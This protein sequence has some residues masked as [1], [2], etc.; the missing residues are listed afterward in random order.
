MNESVKGSDQY[1]LLVGL[2]RQMQ[3]RSHFLSPNLDLIITQLTN[4]NMYESIACQKIKLWT[5][6]DPSNNT[7][8]LYKN[9]IKIDFGWIDLLFSLLGI[10][11]PQ[12]ASSLTQ[13]KRHDKFFCP[14]KKSVFL[15]TLWNP[16]HYTNKFSKNSEIST[17]KD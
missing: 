15:M 11:F 16:Q 13:T 1:L 9:I 10:K 6:V 7:Q 12:P 4:H 14:Y 5:W 17:I 8:L 2:P 3:V